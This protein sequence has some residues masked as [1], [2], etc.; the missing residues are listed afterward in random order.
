MR[1]LLHVDAIVVGDGTVL[2][3]GAVVC[4]GDVVLEVGQAAELRPRAAGLS[5]ERHR[6]VLLPGL[7]NAH[8][9]F[10]LAGLRGRTT[11]G[12]GF[13][14][15]LGT[16][17]TA[18]AE[19]L[20]EERD[21]AI[22]A[23]VEATVAYGVVAVGEVTN[24]LAAVPVLAR[25]LLGTVFHEIFG[26]D[27][28][29]GFRALE[30]AASVPAPLR[31]A[32]A[33]HALY[34]T[35]PD[36]VRAIAATASPLSMHLAEHA[37]ERAFLAH[38]DGPFAGFLAARGVDRAG[39]PIPAQDPVA[40]ADALGLLRP[41]A[42]LVHLSDAREPEL[43]RFAARGAIAVLCPRS[44]LF[45]ETRY[46]PV[47]ALLARGVPLALGTDSLASNTSLDVLAEARAL[48]DKP[49]V[50]A[51]ALLVAATSGGARALGHCDALGRL[52]PGTAPGL[53]LVE[54]ALGDADPARWVLSDLARPRRLLAPA[55]SLPA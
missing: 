25:R 13:V 1:R 49:G 18:R 37:A 5:V 6:G 47:G 20:E 2:C 15:W 10:E 7:V 22:S 9:H 14:P 24:S 41:D 4:D 48:A 53:L 50:D 12:Q 42:A 29:A 17:Q 28:A 35:H 21:A 39:F 36:V 34:S 55:R 51:G 32:R 11:P 30:Q 19:E 45:I 23:A 27:R 16:L 3:D 8:T 52:R 40:Y 26:L 54:G 38:G 31:Y 44:N 43:D 33:P 46:P